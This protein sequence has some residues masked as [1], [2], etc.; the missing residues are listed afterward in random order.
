MTTVKQYGLSLDP[1]I[2][3][4]WMHHLSKSFYTSGDPRVRSVSALESW[5][6]DFNEW[7]DALI[8]LSD[9]VEHGMATVVHVGNGFM[10]GFEMAPAVA[11]ELLKDG[12]IFDLS[13]CPDCGEPTGHRHGPAEDEKPN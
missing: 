11:E 9:L 4:Q 6:D 3:E 7:T 10:P 1:E 2:T 8:R 12:Y 5:L 13:D